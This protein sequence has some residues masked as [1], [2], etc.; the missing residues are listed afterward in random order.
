MSLKW[1]VQNMHRFVDKKDIEF[2]EWMNMFILELF[3]TKIV[4]GEPAIL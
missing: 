4:I 2:H 3:G 1:M